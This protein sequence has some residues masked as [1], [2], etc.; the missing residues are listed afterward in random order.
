MIHCCRESTIGVIVARD[1]LGFHVD[2]GPIYVH[3]G[4]CQAMQLLSTECSNVESEIVCVVVVKA[5]CEHRDPIL[6]IE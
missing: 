4:G 3:G 2:V 1:K 6:L 5:C